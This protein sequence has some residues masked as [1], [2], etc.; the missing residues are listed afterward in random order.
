MK[1]GVGVTTR[2]LEASLIFDDR[3]FPITAPISVGTR[4]GQHSG[5]PQDTT[6]TCPSAPRTRVKMN[7]RAVSL[8]A[9]K[10]D[11]AGAS[12]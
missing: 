3:A 10:E 9:L 8:Y 7:L 4:C 5:H 11:C 6:T 12:D 2:T 1:N